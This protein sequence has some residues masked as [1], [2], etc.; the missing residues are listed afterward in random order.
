MKAKRFTLVLP[1]SSVE[2]LE[3]LKAMTNAPNLTDVV[4]RSLMVYESIAR[5]LQSG[6]RFQMI[7]DGGI[8]VDVEFLMDVERL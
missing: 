2:R 1:Q 4:K 8:T 6:A 5:K 7:T 3:A